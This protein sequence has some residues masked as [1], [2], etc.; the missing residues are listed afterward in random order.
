MLTMA[1]Q[2]KA[3]AVED[4]REFFGKDFETLTAEWRI[5]LLAALE[6]IEDADAQA[7]RYRNETPIRYMPVCDANGVVRR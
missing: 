3:G 5:S 6:A 7:M 2:D 4:Y 1:K